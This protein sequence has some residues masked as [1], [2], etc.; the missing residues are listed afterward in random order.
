[1]GVFDLS[2]I[3]TRL[4]DQRKTGFHVQL[5][6]RIK[7]ECPVFLGRFVAGIKYRNCA[8][9]DASVLQLVDIDDRSQ[10]IFAFE[11]DIQTG[12]ERAVQIGDGFFIGGENLLDKKIRV[13]LGLGQYNNPR[14]KKIRTGELIGIQDVECADDVGH[15]AID[16]LKVTYV[17]SKKNLIRASELTRLH[18]TKAI[19][20]LRGSQEFSAR[21]GCEFKSLGGGDFF[22]S[23]EDFVAEWF[24]GVAKYIIAPN[25]ATDR[26]TNQEDDQNSPPKESSIGGS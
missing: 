5:I 24:L 10:F 16:R 11:V 7:R 21:C 13:L 18:R 8:Y 22:E 23:G 4:V 12:E 9:L 19:K 1:M 14:N 26:K 15:K 2:F 25:P 6:G 3:L 17:V 20:N